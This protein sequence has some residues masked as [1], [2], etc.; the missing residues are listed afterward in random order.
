MEAELHQ[1]LC[2]VLT[3]HAERYP[4]M[5]PCDVVKLIFQNEFGGEH[6]LGE[7]NATLA[8]LRAERA[9]TPDDPAVSPVEDIGNGV[10]RVALAALEATDDALKVLN[11]DFIRSAQVHVGR[12]KAFLEKLDVL[13]RLAETGLFAFTAQE[14]EEYLKEYIEAGCY[15][16]S[17]SPAY[18]E[19]YR[20]AYR[21]VK[22]ANSLVALAW[23]LEQ[24]RRRGERAVIAIDGRCGSGKSTLAARLGRRLGLPVVHMDDFFLR[25]EQRSRARVAKP[26]E[27]ID[28]ERFLEEVLLPLSV[29]ERPVYQPFDCHTGQLGEPVTVEPSPVVLVEGAYACHPSL[30]NYYKRR[31]FLTMEPD[32]QLCRIEERDGTETLKTF[33]ERW[34]PLEERYFSSFR[35]EERCDY[36]LEL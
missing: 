20:P 1:E 22:R 12:R 26:G 5:Q 6:L 35:V 8:W 27:N 19:A 17:H 31:V 24:F 7:P 11:R 9:A 29:G 15:P 25:P 21:V 32:R 23:E 2:R 3:D 28:H 18:R 36:R 14:L 10:V 16:V 30:W 33:R 4:L 34:I 13:R